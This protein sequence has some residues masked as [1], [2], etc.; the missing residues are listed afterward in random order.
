[1]PVIGLAADSGHL[2]ILRLRLY[3]LKFASALCKYC[4][5][6]VLPNDASQPSYGFVNTEKETTQETLADKIIRIIR[7]EAVAN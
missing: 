4:R 5:N 7:N 6:A 3:E 1:M 2:F